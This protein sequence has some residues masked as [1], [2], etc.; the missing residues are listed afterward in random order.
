MGQKNKEQKIMKWKDMT[1]KSKFIFIC[2]NILI[3]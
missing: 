3:T 1:N 2:K